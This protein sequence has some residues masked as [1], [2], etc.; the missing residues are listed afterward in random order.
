MT[1][2]EDG[3]PAREPRLSIPT[4]ADTPATARRKLVEGVRRRLASGELDSDL[5]RVETA[6]ALLD[7]DRRADG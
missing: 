6:F 7:G 2:F 3:R 5:A 4:G 1:K